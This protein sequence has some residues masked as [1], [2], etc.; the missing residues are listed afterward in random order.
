V[1]PWSRTSSYPSVTEEFD[2]VGIITRLHFQSQLVMPS[3]ACLRSPGLFLKRVVGA[4][5]V[6]IRHKVN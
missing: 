2:L 3:E 4:I 5:A 1:I 6:T